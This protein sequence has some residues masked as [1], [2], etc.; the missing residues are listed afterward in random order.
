[1]TQRTRSASTTFLVLLAVTL[2]FGACARPTST[3]APGFGDASPSSTPFRAP[4]RAILDA[5][6]RLPLH[7]EEN[8]GQADPSVR[9]IART[10]GGAVWLTDDGIALGVDGSVIRIGLAGPNAAPRL[11]ALDPLPGRVNY[12]RGRDS[13]GWRTGISTHA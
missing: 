12:Y 10:D 8:R 3:L 13:A 2:V 1:M 4:T 11:H 9:F 5:Y 6:G 7:F